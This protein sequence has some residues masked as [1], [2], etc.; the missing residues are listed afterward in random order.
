MSSIAAENG[1]HVSKITSDSCGS[2]Q[3]SPAEISRRRSN[4]ILSVE[5][6]RDPVTGRELKVEAGANYYGIDPRGDAAGTSTDSWP[7]LDYR[8][9]IRLA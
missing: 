8:A 6:L 7:N 2:G 1:A 9:L 5:D 3:A 4:Q